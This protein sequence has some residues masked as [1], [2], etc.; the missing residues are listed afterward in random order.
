MYLRLELAVGGL[1]CRRG[2][3]RV[4]LL[5]D[6]DDDEGLDVVDGVLDVG[7]QGRGEPWQPGRQQVAAAGELVAGQETG[8]GVL[9]RRLDRLQV[10]DILEEQVREAPVAV[11]PHFLLVTAA[12]K[13]SLDI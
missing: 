8:E 10:L 9:V 13:S 5:L 3:G 7:C 2:G 6:G 4:G 1:L 12:T 11:S